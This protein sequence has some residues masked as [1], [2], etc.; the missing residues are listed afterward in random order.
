MD[1]VGDGV[2]DSVGD[3]SPKYQVWSVRQH[4]TP[5]RTLRDKM[6]RTPRSCQ[7]GGPTPT[8]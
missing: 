2:G 1:S 6:M 4:R 5:Q 3:S 8:D 7:L